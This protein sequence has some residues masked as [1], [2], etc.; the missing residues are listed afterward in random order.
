MASTVKTNVVSVL[1]GVQ[2]QSASQA[3]RTKINKSSQMS[4]L[5]P[6]C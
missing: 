2:I 3:D 5:L 6:T 4:L 1:C